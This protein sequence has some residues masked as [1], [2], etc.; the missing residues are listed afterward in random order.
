MDEGDYAVIVNN[1][2][3]RSSFKVGFQV[4]IAAHNTTHT[5]SSNTS[6]KGSANIDAVT[7]S[8]T[9][10]EGIT[11]IR[12]T[13]SRDT[14]DCVEWGITTKTFVPVNMIMKSPNYWGSKGSGNEHLFF[15]LDK[16]LNPD[17]VRGFFN[18]YLNPVLHEDRKVFEQV[19][20]MMRAPYADEQLSGL[21]F[22]STLRASAQF[23]V[24][25]SKIIKVNF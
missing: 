20:E 1:Y 18:E 12:T 23:R 9:K 22:S 6:P 14:S 4:Q 5:L 3:K 7:F 2:S 11:N 13:L 25:G 15:I 16:C 21:G 10:A 19:A 24:N 17:P 8:F